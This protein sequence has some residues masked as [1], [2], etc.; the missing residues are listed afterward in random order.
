MAPY[1]IMVGLVLAVGALAV[2]NGAQAQMAAT[3]TSVD[4]LA[5]D[6]LARRPLAG[7]LI[8]VAGMGRSV[9]SDAKGRFRMDSVPVG[10]QTFML[11][12]PAFDSIGLSGS[13]QRVVVQ[14]KGKR[15]VL[16][17]PSF[18][19]L[20][21]AACGEAPMAA[22]SG[23]VYGTVRDAATQ[24]GVA[25]IAIDAS[26]IDLIGGGASLAEIAQRR[27]H[28]SSLTDDRGE[29]AVC[30]V[31]LST[32][33]SLSATRDSLD[34]TAIDL[35]ASRARVQRR[36]LLIARAVASSGRSGM[37]DSVGA[38]VVSHDADTA[39]ASAVVMGFIV[40]E[41]GA[42]LPN[43][44]VSV[45]SRPDLL[46]GDDGRFVVRNLSGG[47]KWVSVRAIGRLPFDSLVHLRE[48][49]TTRL[50]VSLSP[51]GVLEAVNVT[52]TLVSTR[53]RGYEDRKRSG[54]GA[55][56]DS[57]DIKSHPTIR[58]LLLTFP[59]ASVKGRLENLAFN[60]GTGAQCSAKYEQVDFRLDGMP[61]TTD[62]LETLDIQSVAAIEVYSRAT[63]IPAELA[64][65][66]KFRCAV[67]I[68]TK[69]GF[70]R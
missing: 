11:Q 40:N 4:G 43:A 53:V 34:V 70:G 33:L 2:S 65:S 58:S 8:S 61:I 55:Y 57:S 19:R 16:A 22:D 63:K 6:S 5:Y 29:F 67:L 24:E 9:T 38:A 47:A 23:L 20:W 1:G 64:G 10:T 15:V 26:W 14:A 27:W 12:H 59:S 54:F 30:G 13:T 7:A 62:A 66:I 37:P 36:D 45:D 50:L 31:P 3:S 28:R 17:L 39:N 21:R 52:A 56:R 69:Q 49:D 25:H 35:P 42:P 68:W 18:E 44:V 60:T 48:G 51:V 41:A 32:P 46:V